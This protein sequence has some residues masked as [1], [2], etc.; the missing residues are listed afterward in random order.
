MV[1]ESN[2]PFL[3]LMVMIEKKISDLIEEPLNSLGYELVRAK[4]ISSDVVQ[5]LIDSESGIN[6]QDCT[7]ATRLIN[8]ILEVAEINDYG[9]EVSSPGTDRP[10]IKPEHF[11][12]YIGSDIKIASHELIDGQKRF[13]GKLT[14]FNKDNNDI[15][16]ACED[17]LVTINLSKMQS[18][19]LY[20]QPLNK[21]P[22]TKRN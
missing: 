10:L 16:I 8:N 7:K 9:L 4:L 19:N 13:I 22:K 21:T 18:A 2:P 1:Y 17:K 12:K 14:N 5:I 6:I 3:L 20:Y 15:E 11:L